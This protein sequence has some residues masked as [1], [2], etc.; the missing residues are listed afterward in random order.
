MSL[1]Q[2]HLVTDVPHCPSLTCVEV[3]AD[4][5]RGARHW[6]QGVRFVCRV[7]WNSSDSLMYRVKQERAHTCSET[8]NIFVFR[9]HYIPAVCVTVAVKQCL[10]F[11]GLLSCLE[12][13]SSSAHAGPGCW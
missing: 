13:V 9:T 12:A 4:S 7:E 3:D 6:H 10:T 8:V 11:T 1:E 2:G 5:Q